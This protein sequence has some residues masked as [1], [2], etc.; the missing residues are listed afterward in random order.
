MKG[1]FFN[2]AYGHNLEFIH[3]LYMAFLED[4]SD[5]VFILPDHFLKQK[6]KM[7]WP[8]A[9]NIRFDLIPSDE[10]FFSKNYHPLYSEYKIA[11]TLKR[12]LKKN[13]VSEAFLSE[14]FVM[15][16][17]LPLFFL[18]H[19]FSLH[20]LI[21]KIHLYR[22]KERKWYGK[23]YDTICY[24]LMA[25]CRGIKHIYMGNDKSAPIYYNK[26][27]NTK[28]FKYIPDP[29]NK[30]DVPYKDM[31]KEYGIP[32]GKIV[33][34]H[35][36]SMG[37]RKGTREI[38]QSLLDM[39]EEER[40]KYVF[41]FAGLIRDKQGFYPYVERL[42]NKDC[43]RIFDTFCDFDFLQQWCMCCD[44][45]LIPYTQSHQS[46]GVLGYAAQYQ[47]PVIGPGFGLIG[48]LIRRNHLGITLPAITS[49][50]LR[51]SYCAVKQ[52]TYRET[53]YLETN[54]VRRFTDIVVQD[55]KY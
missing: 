43:L 9:D 5:V 1:V 21:W 19:K 52:W 18:S 50:G 10:V 11:K 25:K 41:V 28:K 6:E 20:G 16:P 8:H 38:L 23:F 30:I 47:K 51:E 36:G 54:S 35:F 31:R 45:I 46:S 3:H 4:G 27:Y 39:D 7:L 37:G 17:F 15:M 34:Y 14:L 48:K 33:L 40:N 12:Y 2:S 53:D 42:K 26:L 29:F 32:D 24:F 44:A 22:W 13:N 55:L 49:K